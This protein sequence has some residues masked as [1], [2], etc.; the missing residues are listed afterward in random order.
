MKPG[1]NVKHYQHYQQ[2]AEIENRNFYTDLCRF[3]LFYIVVF[4]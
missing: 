2:Y 3:V 1:T 4:A